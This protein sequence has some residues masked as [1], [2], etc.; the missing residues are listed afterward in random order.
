VA[1]LDRVM[2]AAAKLAQEQQSGSLALEEPRKGLDHATI[3]LCISLLD[4]ALFDTIY[5]SIVVV[6][7]AALSIR[8]PRS[9]VNQ[10]ATFSD[11]LHYTPYLSAFI[12]IAQLLVIQQ[13]V[14]A[15]DRGEVPHVADILNVMQERFMVYSTHSPM[16][17]AQKLRS[18]GKQINE[19]TTSVGHI[20][21]TDDS[22]RLS[23]KGLEL[24]MA[25]LKKFLATQTV[26]A[27]SLLGELLRIH[28]DEERDQ[29]VPP[30]NLFQL[31][32]DPANSKPS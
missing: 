10:S 12:K 5:D 4:H 19:V 26:V 1:A 3:Q 13:A 20:S 18:F 31:K 9:S 32:D 7:M 30:V 27:Q 22:Q 25:D 16:N 15:V 29:V 2:Q 21:W 17:W 23:Y 24:G 14:L 8:D 6:F 28:P 11:S